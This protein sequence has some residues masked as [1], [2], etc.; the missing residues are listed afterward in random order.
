MLYPKGS[1]NPKE[2]V[3][4]GKVLYLE[5][6]F[7]VFFKIKKTYPWRCL[8]F[9]FEQ[10]II[11]FPFLRI[12]RQ[13]SHIGFT[14]DRIRIK[15]V[16]IFLFFTFLLFFKG[17]PFFGQNPPSFLWSKSFLSLVK[18]LPFFG[19]NPSFLWSKGRILRS[20]LLFIMCSL[21]SNNCLYYF[22]INKNLFE[23][24]LPV[25]TKKER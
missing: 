19:Q 23:L 22:L 12:K 16:L 14:D 11:I 4:Q 7:P 9:G 2:K 10:I 20:L 18:I 1:C 17:K 15:K 24:F 6:T 3:F 21:R 25:E 8:C 13:F 5:K